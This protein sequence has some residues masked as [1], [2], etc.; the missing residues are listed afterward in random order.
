MEALQFAQTLRR[1][2]MDTLLSQ[3]PAVLVGFS[4]GSVCMGEVN[5]LGG[6]V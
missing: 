3:A 5:C 4:G 6:L 2:G 1:Y